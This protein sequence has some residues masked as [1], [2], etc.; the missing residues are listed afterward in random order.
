MKPLFVTGMLR[1]G[2]SLI[3]VLLT[4]H[5]EIFV[6]YQPYYQFYVS[7]KQRFLEEHSLKKVLP[8][9][10]GMDSNKEERYLFAQ[11]LKNR[12]FNPAEV[13][14]L[15]DKATAGKGGSAMEL[16]NKITA[17]PG[18]FFD[19]QIQLY[20]LLADHFKRG[21]SRFIGSKEVL[22]EEYIP[23]LID[24]S[25]RCLIIV[26]DPR[27]VIASACHGRY[28]EKVGDR[29]PLLMLIR[30]WR[31][32][33]AY[34]LAYHNNPLVQTIRYEDLIGG[35]NDTLQEIA[36]WL[37]VHSFPDGLLHKPLHD[38]AGKLWKGNSSFGDKNGI[39][40]SK[41]ET[42]RTLLTQEEIRFIEACTKPELTM[43]GYSYS[44]DLQRS[45]IY[46]FCEDVN[47][48]REAY[49]SVYRLDAENQ[50]LELQRWDEAARNQ[51]KNSAERVLFIFPDVFHSLTP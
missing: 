51:Y 15:V 29:Y 14:S 20:T 47:G 1:S 44:N 43:L 2:T 13:A 50:E 41:E 35:S 21:T 28:H 25:V 32:S 39:E 49:L 12:R 26:R 10:D 27:A 45:D 24:S 4:N 11:W 40:P 7:I 38:H 30:L 33:A 19:I 17:L 31:K 5:P 46:D 42:W 8:L 48:V 37:D 9:G 22:C 16:A 23:A 3:Q 34:W 36:R 18:T 6:A